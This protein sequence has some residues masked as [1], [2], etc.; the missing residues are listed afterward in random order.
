MCNTGV[1]ADHY[2]RLNKKD[3]EIVFHCNNCV[4]V[5]EVAEAVEESSEDENEA[6]DESLLGPYNRDVPEQEWLD[7]DGEP[8][9]PALDST[10]NISNRD[11]E[12]DPEPQE[13]SINV[14]PDLP[15]DI[16]P[17]QPIRFKVLESG[18]KRGGKLLVSSNGYSYG[19]KRVNN[20]ST[21]W[22]CSIRSK[23]V[24]CHAT[25]SQNGDHFIQ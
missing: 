13:E 15:E 2:H 7:S 17:D 16:I 5:D 4:E 21:S 9:Q 10:F 8:D 20:S 6:Q 23:K 3:I 11:I 22:T 12:E 24:R 18:S 25:V 19:V 14:D 1:S